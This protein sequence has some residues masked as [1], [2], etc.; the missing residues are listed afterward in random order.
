MG[1]IIDMEENKGLQ[2]IPVDLHNRRKTKQFIK[3]HYSIYR[4]D[5]HWVAPLII[6]YLE[7]LNPKK[8][9]YFRHSEV[10]PFIAVRDGRIVGRITAHENNNHVTYHNE[11]VGF[12]GFFE[13][14][15][16]REAAKGLFFA[17]ARWLREKGLETMRGPMSFSVNGDP[18]G[19]LV[20]GFDSA[21]VVGMTYNPEYYEKLITGSGFTKAQDFYAYHF[22]VDKKAPDKFRH[23][24]ERAMRDP[25]LN[26]RRAKLKN[27]DQ[28]VEKLKFIYNEALSQNWGAVPMTD[29]EF[30]HF[31]GELKLAVDE[32]ATIIAEYE[33]KPVGLSLV[34]KDFNQA[35]KPVNGR[36]LP[37]GIIKLLRLRNKITGCRVPV[38]GV[39]EP[40]RNRGIDV[41]L[42]VKSMDY[43]YEKG[44]R[45]AELSWIL[46]SNSMMN[47]IL[48][49]LGM[50]LYKTYRVYDRD[51]R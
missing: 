1:G 18:I 12:F 17:A 4:D 30:D 49:H 8:N 41:A 34:F 50:S 48:E 5:P 24:A 26:L 13:C 45:D 27:L 21:P 44:Y 11:K 2:I 16:D 38:L 19:L 36:L 32:D 31:T 37:F 43:G 20:D 33:G 22:S 51:I 46:E 47:K 40:Y 9:P 10:Q 28:E 39:L 7:R 42:Y 35:L 3:F 25:K 29:E 14:E 23:I 6:D 15:N